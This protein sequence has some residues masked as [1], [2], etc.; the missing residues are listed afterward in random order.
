LGCDVIAVPSA[1]LIR[2]GEAGGEAEA[3]IPTS[4]EIWNGECV[5]K[6]KVGEKWGS[7]IDEKGE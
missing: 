1:V 4:K 6:W 3:G 2:D 5:G 7:V